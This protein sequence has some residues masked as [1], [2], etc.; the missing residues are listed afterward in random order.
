MP[1][2]LELLAAVVFL[3]AARVLLGG[4]TAYIVPGVRGAPVLTCTSV[5]LAA[6][7]IPHASHLQAPGFWNWGFEGLR[8][9]G[10]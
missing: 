1:P 8:V 10:G 7:T 2:H 4:G 6:R 3:Q 5:R 9:W